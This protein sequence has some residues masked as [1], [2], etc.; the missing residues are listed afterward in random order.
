MSM[1]FH[2]LHTRFFV[3]LFLIF[4]RYF[5]E[6]LAKKM[7]FCHAPFYPDGVLLCFAVCFIVVSCLR[8]FLFD[9]GTRLVAYRIYRPRNE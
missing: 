7:S 6:N 1:I 3:F 8:F 2:G 4:V 5:T 9:G